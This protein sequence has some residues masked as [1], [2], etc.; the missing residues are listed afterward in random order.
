MPHRLVYA[1][2]AAAGIHFY[3]LVKSDVREPVFMARSS[4]CC[5]SPG[6]TRFRDLDMLKNTS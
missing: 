5:R 1:N 6:S 2:P 4:C 3:W